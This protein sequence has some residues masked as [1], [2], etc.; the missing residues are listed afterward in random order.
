MN[1][2]HDDSGIKS[3][4]I[5]GGIS[6]EIPSHNEK[7]EKGDWIDL[8]ASEDM[9]I[10][11]GELAKIP[12]GVSIQLPDGYE[13]IVAPRSSTCKN[14]GILMSSS[15]GII[16]ESFCGNTDIWVFPAYAIRDTTIKKND[17]ICQFRIVKHQPELNFEVVD[18]LDNPDRGGYGSSGKN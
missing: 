18:K 8:R 9:E 13:A 10:K 15:I 2:P 7:K 17:R 5:K 14:F 1:I 12:L 16:D 3:E 6:Y 11:A 4:F